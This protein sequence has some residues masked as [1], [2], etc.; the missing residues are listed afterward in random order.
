MKIVIRDHQDII[1]K[2]FLKA[3]VHYLPKLCFLED[4]AQKLRKLKKFN[5]Y[6]DTYVFTGRHKYTALQLLQV[7]FSNMKI[8]YGSSASIIEIDPAAIMPYYPEHKVAD[9]CSLI[10]SGNLEITGTHLLRDLYQF[11]QDNVTSLRAS[12]EAGL[13]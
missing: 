5:S 8:N 11:V 4:K 10:D 3:I 7:G 12:Y 1:D 13:M 9:L 6:L 2:N